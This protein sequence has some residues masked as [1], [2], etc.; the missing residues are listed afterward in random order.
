MNAIRLCIAT[1]LAVLCVPGLIVA[2]WLL[3][4]WRYLLLVPIAA[5]LGVFAFQT[6]RNSN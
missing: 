1:A 4:D 5:M 3:S 2:A 6:L